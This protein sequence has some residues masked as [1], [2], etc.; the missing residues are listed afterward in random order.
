M[1]EIEEE[2]RRAIEREREIGNGSLALGIRKG[3]EAS[4]NAH[5]PSLRRELSQ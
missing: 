1:K 5:K 3:N 4:K 2:K